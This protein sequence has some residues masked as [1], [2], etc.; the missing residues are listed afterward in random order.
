MASADP[1]SP[2]FDP[3]LLNQSSA[4][5][6]E[7]VNFDPRV[8]S[9]APNNTSPTPVQE[10]NSYGVT[11]SWGDPNEEAKNKIND[12]LAKKD[13][14][15]LSKKDG[16]YSD[17]NYNYKDIPI[18][19]KIPGGKMLANF[20]YPEKQVDYKQMSSDLENIIND[21][22]N[23]TD[24]KVKYAAF[25]AWE[26]IK[27]ADAHDNGVIGSLPA[28]VYD[29]AKSVA[30]YGSG[31][32]EAGLF[33]RFVAQPA[34]IATSEYIQKKV[35][36]MGSYNKDNESL[37]MDIGKSIA[38]NAILSSIFHVTFGSLSSAKKILDTNTKQVEA[39]NLGEEVY[40]LQQNKKQIDL[41]QNQDNINTNLYN[42]NKV[43]PIKN[44]LDKANNDLKAKED[45]IKKAKQESD[46]VI[47]K[48]NTAIDNY[49]YKR[50]E[51]IAKRT[52]N[53]AI[54]TQQV[55]N[56]FKDTVV[57]E[58]DN[59]N[60]YVNKSSQQIGRVITKVI[61]NA[62]EKATNQYEELFNIL[63]SAKKKIDVSDDIDNIA[64]IINAEKTQFNVVPEKPSN[65]F[66]Q[67]TSLQT[68]K[69]TITKSDV[70]EVVNATD[71]PSHKVVLDF[72][73]G[74]LNPNELK[75]AKKILN[76]DLTN[77]SPRDAHELKQ[78][79]EDA[80]TKQMPLT[81]K[82][83]VQIS[84]LGRSQRPVGVELNNTGANIS[85]KIDA[86][87]VDNQY[88]K[89]SDDYHQLKMSQSA[90]SNLFNV[91]G[92]GNYIIKPN[93]L[94]DMVNK[95]NKG[96]INYA[97]GLDYINKT[98]PDLSKV[99]NFL[100]SFE[101]GALQGKAQKL[102]NGVFDTVKA[103]F[104]KDNMVNFV[105]AANAIDVLVNNGRLLKKEDFTQASLDTLLQ[106]ARNTGTD[107]SKIEDV[108]NQFAH[109]EMESGSITN[110][111][112]KL[113]NQ[114]MNKKQKLTN[115]FN[116]QQEALNPN[117]ENVGMLQ[118]L[119][120]E[121]KSNAPKKDL[122]LSQKE[123]DTNTELMN[124]SHDLHEASKSLEESKAN[125]PRT[126]FAVFSTLKNL[127]YTTAAMTG[128]PMAYGAGHLT[129]ALASG[130]N[131]AQTAYQFTGGRVLKDTVV[132]R[133]ET[134]TKWHN[135]LDKSGLLG[136]N[137]QQRQTIINA[138]ND[139]INT[140]TKLLGL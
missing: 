61:N 125:M 100:A 115:E 63:D 56:D 64:K 14:V 130:I 119:Y 33:T 39:N 111:V 127:A 69:S 94:S 139:F 45:A 136:E 35:K 43:E 7:P 88:N 49:E 137:T 54:K 52:T 99:Y 95:L 104:K 83:G 59:V 105:D 108:Y 92:E 80:G 1:R 79:L 71:M 76:S 53:L 58:L 93:T 132:K 74:S 124:K 117:R 84:S 106:K 129:A 86:L 70:G 128:Q 109:L 27:E 8:I 131:A 122:S 2:E 75:T 60:Q 5:Q 73:E 28:N 101:G 29:F 18:I 107:Y 67:N 38:M 11:G 25:K 9:N 30:M 46:A 103:Q 57:S 41:K 37:G 44:E 20:V 66:V 12:I 6:Q 98:N 133:L 51:S 72:L 138:L 87:T 91:D 3:R 21:K 118:E 10:S 97:D 78:I 121:T 22:Q 90:I 15:N 110:K 89:L 26:D 135:M 40:N 42:E 34:I 81:D 82:N 113:N 126:T 114:L 102:L 4:D 31:A 96:T 16:G 17:T 140:H 13:K 116:A 62:K 68:G 77:V 32:G 134:M 65:Q 55:V 48:T 112:K 36:D 85:N 47:Q 120:N 19:N 23:V 24:K 50:K 123:Q